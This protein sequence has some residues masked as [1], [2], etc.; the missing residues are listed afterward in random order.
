MIRYCYIAQYKIGDYD[1]EV[2][3]E[4]GNTNWFHPNLSVILPKIWSVA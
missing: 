4:V 2:S 1:F 3:N